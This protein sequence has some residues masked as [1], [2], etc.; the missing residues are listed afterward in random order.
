MKKSYFLVLITLTILGVLYLVNYNLQSPNWLPL[1][2]A[3][4][5]PSPV[6]EKSAMDHDNGKDYE[7]PSYITGYED[8]ACQQSPT[9][10]PDTCASLDRLIELYILKAGGSICGK[11]ECCVVST[12]EGQGHIELD[13]VSCGQYCFQK[14][15]LF[16]ECKSSAGKGYCWCYDVG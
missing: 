7:T 9:D 1:V 2:S 14:Y 12:Q 16:G 13:D 15:S 6:I 10:I 3:T 4:P 8:L 11:D 5:T